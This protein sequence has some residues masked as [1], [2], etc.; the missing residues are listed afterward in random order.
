MGSGVLWEV[1]KP[2]FCI[3]KSQEKF[4]FQVVS[5][6]FPFLF[7]I[8]PFYHLAVLDSLEG[9]LV[10]IRKYN[11]KRNLQFLSYYLDLLKSCYYYLESF[12]L[13]DKETDH[14]KCK[15]KMHALEK[16]AELSILLKYFLD[17][18]YK[19]SS[20]HLYML[21]NI[22]NDFVIHKNDILY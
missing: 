15:L 21:S 8:F 3:Q 7:I 4:G 12:L 13:R 1:L 6:K 20:I 18:S 17:F 19:F 2:L 5:S 9:L 22:L 16:N 11:V 14:C 10:F